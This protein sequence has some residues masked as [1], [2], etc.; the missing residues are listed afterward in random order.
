MTGSK[1]FDVLIVG[2]GH[3]G[4]QV[5]IS[6]RQGGF[7]GSIV[8]VS[9][10]AEYPYERPPLSKEFFSGEKSAERIRIRPEAFW[11][12]REIALLL[13]ERVV[14]LD[15]SK[16]QVN[17]AGGLVLSYG[18]LVWAAG[19]CA[20][21]IDMPA[22]LRSN[23]L[24]VRTLQDAERLKLLSSEAAHVVMVGGGYIGLEAAAVLSKAGKRVTLVE[25]L[26]RVL[27]RVAGPELSRFV[28]A[29][30]RSHGVELRLATAI[31][32]FQGREKVETI[33]LADG[34]TIDCDLVV[35]GIGIIPE[36]EPLSDAGATCGNGVEIDEFCRTTLPDVFAIGDCAAHRSAYAECARIRLESVQNAVDMA[37]TVA[38]YLLG[39]PSAYNC[40]PWFWSNQ[41]DLR[42]QTIGLS[43]GY[44]A[45][46][47]R[48]D[49][50]SGSFSVVYLKDERVIALDCVNAVKDYV[51]GKALVMAGARIPAG[52]LADSGTALKDLLQG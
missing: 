43:I 27:A 49:L 7:H 15:P 4:A 36:V 46:V 51:Q 34:S 29:A 45:T 48:G 20:R 30:H 28:E 26:D 24:T 44:D 31:S 16:H 13:N 3:G 14:S 38:D 33:A 2:G 35:V 9:D 40:V 21:R 25:A 42:I 22:S 47:V 32:G 41:Y 18:K 23:V 37:K 12:E 5:A 52:R 1:T 6:L 8:I 11:Q 10:E 39:R 17:T 19:G 50:N